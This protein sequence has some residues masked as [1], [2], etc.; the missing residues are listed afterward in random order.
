[1]ALSTKI[2]KAV[3]K[4]QKQAEAAVADARG[5][6]DGKLPDAVTEARIPGV[7]SNL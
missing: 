6:L 1:M 2:T 7:Y 5:R 4:A 3:K